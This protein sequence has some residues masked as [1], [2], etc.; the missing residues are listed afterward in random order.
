MVVAGGRGVVER[1]RD[2]AG[3]TL[4]LREPALAFFFAC[5]RGQRYPGAQHPFCIGLVCVR[6][7]A[8][9]ARVQRAGVLLVRW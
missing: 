9:A 3:G 4:A 1:H 5:C 6:G 2:E 7:F 8:E